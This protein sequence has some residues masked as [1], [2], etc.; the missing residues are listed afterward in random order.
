MS[1]L[2][3]LLCGVLLPELVILLLVQLLQH[4]KSLAYQFLLDNLDQLVLLQSFTGHIKRKVVGIDNTLD[5]A[6]VAG[7]HFLEVVADE[8]AAHKQLQ[9]RI[10]N[11]STI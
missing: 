11:L 9:Q 4:V 7:H 2:C 3:N 1:F 6:Q 5:E 8:D 10:S